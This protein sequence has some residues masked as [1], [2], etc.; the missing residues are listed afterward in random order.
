MGL[1]YD[2]DENVLYPLAKIIKNAVFENFRDTDGI[3]HQGCHAAGADTAESA[4]DRWTAL[5][6]VEEAMRW[7]LNALVAKPTKEPVTCL[8]CLTQML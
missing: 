2:A 8:M 5:T 4:C 7:A 1:I 3:V 6:T